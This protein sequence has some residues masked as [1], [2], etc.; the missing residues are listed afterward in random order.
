MFLHSVL[1]LPRWW[2]DRNNRGHQDTPPEE[3]EQHPAPQPPT[4]D[5]TAQFTHMCENVLTMVNNQN[6]VSTQNTVQTVVQALSTQQQQTTMQL[7]ELMSN[8]MQQ[9]SNT[10]GQQ[11]ANLLQMV[12][13][14][15]RR[16]QTPS[17]PPPNPRGPDDK[18]LGEMTHAAKCNL[19]ITIMCPLHIYHSEWGELAPIQLMRHG[20]IQLL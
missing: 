17:G 15:M 19:T 7:T 9:L 14:E 6:T 11:A 20:L 12:M 4:T 5:T 8:I 3:P 10:Q 16:G 2:A 18:E 13:Q 1:C